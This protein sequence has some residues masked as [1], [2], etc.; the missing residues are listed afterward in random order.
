MRWIYK[1]LYRMWTGEKYVENITNLSYT[2]FYYNALE[3]E[4]GCILLREEDDK[5]KVLNEN[6]IKVTLKRKDVN[7]R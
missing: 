3:E 7:K 1:L 6:K 4:V 5:C 2:H